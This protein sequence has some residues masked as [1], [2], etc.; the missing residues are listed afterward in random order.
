MNYDFELSF[1]EQ[2][3]QTQ[4]AILDYIKSNTPVVESENAWVKDRVLSETWGWQ[5]EWLVIRKIYKYKNIAS[6]N[7]NGEI[8]SINLL[9]WSD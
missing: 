9:V 8:L 1:D 3:Y 6:S 2:D 5:D 4:E 7:K